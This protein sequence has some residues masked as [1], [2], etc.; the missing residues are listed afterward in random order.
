MSKRKASRV[1]FIYGVVSALALTAI[2]LFVLIAGW[3]WRQSVWLAVGV[4]VI[5]WAI[6]FSFLETHRIAN[7]ARSITGPKDAIDPDTPRQLIVEPPTGEPQV[8]HEFHRG[9]P[10]LDQ[11]QLTSQLPEHLPLVGK[12][13]KHDPG[14]KRAS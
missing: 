2:V 10:G 14:T 8:H 12:L 11:G 4:L 7:G 6:L 3:S 1:V 9:S 13:Q 5:V